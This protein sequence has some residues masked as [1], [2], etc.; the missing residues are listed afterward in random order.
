MSGSFDE[1]T[2]AVRGAAQARVCLFRHTDE[3]RGVGAWVQE[4]MAL[5]TRLVEQSQQLQQ[6]RGA[7]QSRVAE[8]RRTEVTLRELERFGADVPTYRSVGRMFLRT[9]LPEVRAELD[10]RRARLGTEADRLTK[11]IEALD[12]AVRDGESNL[13]ELVQKKMVPAGAGPRAAA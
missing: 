13:R 8:R 1:D 11:S 6:A 4:L 12:A 9:P 3:A 7:Q 10:A 5:Q 2:R